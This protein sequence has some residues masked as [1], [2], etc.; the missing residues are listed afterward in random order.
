MQLCC[1]CT[2]ISLILLAKVKEKMVETTA[3][4][5]AY[6]RH[7]QFHFP[8]IA[9]QDGKDLL[10]L[11]ESGIG[12]TTL[13][14]LLAGLL[15]PV[16]GH[17]SIQGVDIGNL[18][19]KAMDHFRGQHIGMVFQRPHFVSA[20]SLRENL[21]LVQYLAAHKQRPDHVQ[22]VLMRL[23]IGHKL[24]QKPQRLSQGEQQRAAIALAIINEPSLILADEPTASL[25]DKNCLKVAELLKEQA[26]ATSAHL[27][28][29][30]HD[31][32]LKHLFENFIV[33]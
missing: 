11:G 32:R 27:I 1:T 14:H 12:K 8:D 3:L 33:L 23:G 22:E 5:F 2:F 29:I 24:H 26:T 9:L 20:L 7:Q 18:S 25:D 10:I 13:L 6:H 16:S 19:A 17:I 31:Q 21:L 15:K 30:T 4:Q 28:I